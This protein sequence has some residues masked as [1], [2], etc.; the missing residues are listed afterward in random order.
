MAWD[1]GLQDVHSVEFCKELLPGLQ[2]VQLD[3][4]SFGENDPAMQTLHNVEP[5][6]AENE[7]K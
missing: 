4:A 7:P 1:P 2:V 3:A 6:P 5:S